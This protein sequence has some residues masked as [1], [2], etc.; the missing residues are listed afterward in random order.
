M[1]LKFSLGSDTVQIRQQE[2]EAESVKT[3][4]YCV[5]D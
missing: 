1:I 5:L 3:F 4:D 2:I